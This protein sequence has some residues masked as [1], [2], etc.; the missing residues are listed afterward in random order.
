LNEE[1]EKRIKEYYNIWLLKAFFDDDETEAREEPEIVAYH[2]TYSYC[3][4]VEMKTMHIMEDPFWWG[5]LLNSLTNTR[6]GGVKFRGSNA[7]Y[8]LDGIGVWVGDTN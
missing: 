6:I 3:V 8:I 7:K 1:T 5:I 4:V 2:G